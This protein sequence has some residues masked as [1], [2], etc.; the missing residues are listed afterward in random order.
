LALNS[1]FSGHSPCNLHRDCK[2]W[3]W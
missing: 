1:Q 3:W 2:T